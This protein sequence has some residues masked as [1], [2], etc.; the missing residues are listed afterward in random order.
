MIE[1]DL[2]II[3]R[4][5]KDMIKNFMF[6]NDLGGAW[7]PEWVKRPNWEACEGGNFVAFILYRKTMSRHHKL[8]IPCDAILFKKFPQ[9]ND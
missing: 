6:Y 3:L 5:E 8:L 2:E 7:E 9:S 4:E 1:N